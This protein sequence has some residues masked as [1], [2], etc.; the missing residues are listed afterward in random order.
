MCIDCAVDVQAMY[1]DAKSDQLGKRPIAL[2]AYT[3]ILSL[4]SMRFAQGFCGVREPGSGWLVR[5]IHAQEH[6]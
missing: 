1:I 4:S 5:R 2:L 6:G 3:Y